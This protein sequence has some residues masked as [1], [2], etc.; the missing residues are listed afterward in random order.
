ME[1]SRFETSS[2]GMED[3][4]RL[5]SAGAT[6]DTYRIKLYGKLHFLKRLKP[7]F[8]NDIRY[9]EAL[10]KEFETGYRLEHPHL[11][12]YVSMADDGILMEYVDGETLTERMRAQPGLFLSR[13]A[14]DKFLLQLLDAV[15][16]LHSH[17]VLHLDLKP[18]NIMLTRVNND[19]KL[20]DLGC[21]RS[22]TFVDT[23]GHTA[24]FAAPEQLS[25]GVV[26]ERTDIYAI[27][28]ILELLP[29]RH[30]YNKVIARCTA[31]RPEDRYQSV[32]DVVKAVS[33]RPN[34][35]RAAIALSLVVALVALGIFL[36][37]HQDSVAPVEDK[38]P[39]DT[40]SV[41]TAIAVPELTA[42]NT[43]TD[44]ASRST[45]NTPTTP[46]N[47]PSVAVDGTKQMEREMNRLIDVAYRSTIITFCDSIF[48]S[49]TV[50]QQWEEQSSE[51]H[52]QVLQ[53]AAD[54][55]RK[56]PDIPESVIQQ[57]VESCFQALV[58]YVFNRMRE[59]GK[60]ASE[61]R[62]VIEPEL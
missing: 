13:K 28:K 15:A 7:E 52:A 27:G 26:D 55:S 38:K 50:G 40:T 24:A 57:H 49:L 19:V 32:A 23:Q 1:S 14:A 4:F 41:S 56:Y 17:Q 18:D 34:T 45:A 10:R 12:R 2:S 59:N 51:F 36:A 60:K 39:A 3:V 16:Y 8:A 5:E 20:V 6:C 35:Y 46:P 62:L 43:P 22:D 33:R 42:P 37:V 21:C 44:G 30:I 11:V 48:P 53:V 29:N 47:K 31:A 9:R 25:G 61:D 58:G 54:L